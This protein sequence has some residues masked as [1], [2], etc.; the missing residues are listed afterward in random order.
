MGGKINFPQGGNKANIFNEHKTQPCCN[1]FLHYHFSFKEENKYPTPW[2]IT[3]M[4]HIHP[5]VLSQAFRRINVAFR[6]L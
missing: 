1:F 6:A 3:F 2:L 5:A 4:V